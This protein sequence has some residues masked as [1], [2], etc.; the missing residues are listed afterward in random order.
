MV[1]D[2]VLD[3]HAFRRTGC[4]D[5]GIVAPAFGMQ[6]RLQL[7]GRPYRTVFDATNVVLFVINVGAGIHR[8]AQ[9]PTRRIVGDLYLPGRAPTKKAYTP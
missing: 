8:A 9:L 7:A 6:D 5:V 1:A 4:I 3:A 2:A